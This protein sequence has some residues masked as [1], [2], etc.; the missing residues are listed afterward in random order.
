MRALSR[1]IILAATFLIA[2]SALL[3]I[4]PAISAEKKPPAQVLFTNVNI[5]DGKS[6]KLAEGM[7]VLVEG[8]LIKTVSAEQIATAADATVIDGGGRTLM[9][10]LI[11][12][13]SHL[14]LQLAGIMA[15]ETATWDEIG[16]RTAM[17]AEDWLLDGFTTVRDVGGMNGKGVKRLV[18]NGDI[19]GP[20]IYPSGAIISQ[21]SGHADTRNLNMRNPM[22]N[23]V[24][25]SNIERLDIA[26]TVD[27]RPAVLAAVRR[28]LKLGASQIKIMGGGGVATEYDPWH[29][30]GYTMDETR[31]AVEAARDYGTYVASHLNH[32][33]SIKRALEAG[34]ISIEHAFAIDE[35]TMKMLVDKGA[36]L[37]TQMTGTSEELFKLPSLT[38]ESLRKLSIAREDMKHYFELVKTYQPKQVFAIDAVL[39]LPP[40]ADQQ[41]A[42]EI[43]LFAHHF[44]NHAM[45]KAATSTAGELLAESGDLNPYP[46]GAIGVI[47]AGAYADMLLVDG[48]PLED[49]TVIGG[50][51]MWYD[52]PPRDGVE[53][54]RIIMKDGKVYKN[55]LSA[56]S[57]AS[58][59]EDEATIRARLTIDGRIA[60]YGV[61]FKTDSAEL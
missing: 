4:A 54:I 40:Q 58:P 23:S 24:M 1:T 41:R 31:A 10:G 37:S 45:L 51:E 57:P 9:P 3:D 60:I 43:W 21:T 49:I 8:N 6:D 30:T 17:A 47:E 48:N 52:A 33:A 59:N 36:Y 7:S 15:L 42:H 18:D 16:A 39:T 25:D 35:S 50:N 26:R 56:A 32:P 20:R 14:G 34:V 22:L 46:L 44:G 55:T 53:T 5:F 61:Q 29:S 38:A 28:N 19:P 12:M 11:D 2:G 27:G 13:H